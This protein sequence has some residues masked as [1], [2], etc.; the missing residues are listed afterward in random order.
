MKSFFALFLLILFVAS[1][2]AQEAPA[3]LTPQQIA[4]Q[5]KPLHGKTL[6]LVFD[7]TESTRHGGVFE[8]GSGTGVVNRRIPGAPLDSEYLTS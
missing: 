8:D 4:A 7:V 1:A 2:Y 6:I 5:I 3:P